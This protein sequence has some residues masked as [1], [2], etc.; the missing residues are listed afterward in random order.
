[1]VQCSHGL[2]IFL[3]LLGGE[4]ISFSSLI[5]LS[6][7]PYP[8]PFD[9]KAPYPSPQVVHLLQSIHIS[10]AEDLLNHLCVWLM[11]MKWML[12]FFLSVREQLYLLWLSFSIS[13]DARIGHLDTV[14]PTRRRQLS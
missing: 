6:S 7:S 14:I 4:T 3:C 13:A 12:L 8:F 5:C 1:M 9:S 10:S 11:V 2:L